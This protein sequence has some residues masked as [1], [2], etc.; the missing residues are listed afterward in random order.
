MIHTHSV[1]LVSP[2]SERQ[3]LYEHCWSAWFT[4]ASRC[5]F[6]LS[7]TNNHTSSS[8]FG[9]PDQG[10]RDNQPIN[11]SHEVREDSCA[12]RTSRGSTSEQHTLTAC[13]S[14]AAQPQTA[15]MSTR[16]HLTSL[17]VRPQS[18]TM[19]NSQNQCT[20]RQAKS[21]QNKTQS[22]REVASLGFQMARQQR[23]PELQVQNMLEL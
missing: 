14:T 22:S 15:L 7:G 11:V 6:V 13:V 10:L 19:I 9:H 16:V 21:R 18:A 4:S 1:A 23:E 3:C 5:C 17:H 20:T 8:D 2:V 12:F